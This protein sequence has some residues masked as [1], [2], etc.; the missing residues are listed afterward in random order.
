MADSPPPDAPKKWLPIVAVLV[1]VGALAWWS[2]RTSRDGEAL[3]PPEE[4]A[5]KASPGGVVRGGAGLGTPVAASHIGSD[6]VVAGF[7]ASAKA[8][9]VQRIDDK[10][11]VAAERLVLTD[12]AWSNDADLK[13]T[14][15]AEGL[16][17]TWRGL[18]AGK[19]V[20]HLVILGPDLAPKGEPTE[21]AAVSCATRDAVWFSDG[22]HALARPW[23]GAPLKVSLPKDKD[24]ALLCGQHRAFAILDDEDRT[25]AL[26]LGVD[27]GTP[28]PVPMIRESDFGDDEQRELADYTV[29]DDVGFVR[30]ASSGALALREL[31]REGAQPIR[32]LKTAIGRDDDIVAV[33]ASPR[34][35][36]IVYTQDVTEAAGGEGTME[37]TAST[38]ISAL[39]IDRQ[40]H[41]ESTIELSP[42]RAG[43]EV[44]PFFTSAV[45]D[46][47]SIAWPERTGGV[48]RARAPIASLSHIRVP[49]SGTAA[50]K[51]I[52]VSADALVDAGCDLSSCFAVALVRSDRA[53]G[54]TAGTAKVLRYE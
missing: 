47:V 3:T 2:A 54:G 17:I 11:R 22:S 45:G 29:G 1:G 16:A 50:T 52:E 34:F 24:A 28:A 41:E 25:S 53:D 13:L 43:Y 51:R 10:D 12:A 23:S 9:R 18:R 14:A 15:S 33:D 4:S 37:T 6:V 26:P 49:K 42:G 46:D 5:E 35:V 19:L 8:I 32:R 40:T 20:R 21:V 7:D 31:T 30:L 27:A 44:G 38:K 36:V 48:G 39:R